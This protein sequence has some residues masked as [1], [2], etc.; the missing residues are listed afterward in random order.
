MESSRVADVKPRIS[1]NVDKIK[2]W[3]FPDIADPSQLKTLKLPDPL[4]ASKVSFIII[5]RNLK[6]VSSLLGKAF[7][8]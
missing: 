7:D 6:I 8:F 5:S 4:T 2:S 1:D 3:K